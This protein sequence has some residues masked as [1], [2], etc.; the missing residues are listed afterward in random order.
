MILTR[1]AFS[2][3]FAAASLAHPAILRAGQPLTIGYVPANAM[4]WVQSVAIDKGFYREV[5]FDAQPAVMQNSPHA[6]WM[7]I[8]GDFQVAAAQPEPFVAAVERGAA[9]L[10]A[11][12]AP[13]NAA[14]WGLIG[15][16]AT[17]SLADLKGQ[18]IGVSS[19]HTAESGLT[20]K[21][22][23][24]H[25]IADPEVSYLQAGTSPSKI[26]A[27]QKGAIGAAVLYQPWVEAAVRR[28]LPLLARY[29]SI[30]AYP[31]TLYVVQRAWA[32]RGDAGKRVAHAIQKGH[33]WLWNPANRAEAIRILG[34]YTGRDEAVLD[35]V[36][37]DYF[38]S[39]KLYSR[40]GAI[41]LAGLQRA[42]NDMA[43]DGE[44][45]KV[46]PPARQ[47]ALDPSLGAILA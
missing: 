3:G 20:T 34:K 31:P 7:A 38:V 8:A 46:A 21:L 10:G 40:D 42:L 45:F 35:A 27:L 24:A 14:D 41:A 16:S 44:I 6:L 29:G 2:T 23:A 26:A 19:L 22:F 39:K 1:R 36:Y 17:G 43:E 13:M 47:F 30:R 15:S 25:G 33:A 28:G 11:I 5:G 32:S 9:A 18:V 4:H 12:A 37:R